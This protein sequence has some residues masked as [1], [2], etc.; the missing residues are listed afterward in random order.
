MKMVAGARLN[1]AQTRIT[2]LRPYAV[3]THAVLASITAEPNGSAPAAE[4]TALAVVGE[5][6]NEV[7]ESAGVGWEDK[8]AHPLLVKRAEKRVL[9]L[10]LTSD[11]GLCGGFNTNLNKRAE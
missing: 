10:V 7:A 9:L 11:R 3:K 8:P 4:E 6:V 5:A 2:E 1:K